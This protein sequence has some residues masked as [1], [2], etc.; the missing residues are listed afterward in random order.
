ME[1]CETLLSPTVYC[2]FPCRYLVVD[3]QVFLMKI[4]RGFQ[5]GSP[6][7]CGSPSTAISGCRATCCPVVRW[8]LCTPHGLVFWL[9]QQVPPSL[10]HLQNKKVDILANQL[11]CI[12]IAIVGTISHDECVFKGIRLVLKIKCYT[13][14]AYEANR[15][16]KGGRKSNTEKFGMH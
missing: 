14:I 12:V 5:K 16:L 3:T 15:D 13:M 7:V 1:Q 4:A 6:A 11:T 9:R 10:K 2:S 8:T